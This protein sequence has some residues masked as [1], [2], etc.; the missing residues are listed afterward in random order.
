M[1]SFDGS[2]YCLVGLGDGQLLTWR[3][4]VATGEG[5]SGEEGEKGGGGKGRR[6]KREEEE[7]R[8]G[9]R[10]GIQAGSNHHGPPTAL[11]CVQAACRSIPPLDTSPTPTPFPPPPPPP[12]PMHACRRPVGAQAR[13]AG[14]QAAAA[15][16]LLQKRRHERLRRER[17]AHHH[18][19]LEQEGRVFE[20]ERE[21]GESIII[22]K[23]EQKGCVFE[24]ERE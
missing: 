24:F 3:L 21:R 18:L 1:N 23:L 16:D 20:F 5:R 8:G 13:A 14:H 15:Q 2:P 4:N 22:Y 7:K 19:Q 17:P 9:G 6:R 10:G 11:K 12:P